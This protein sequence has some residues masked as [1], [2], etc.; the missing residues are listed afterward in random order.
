M[1]G[2]TMLF[3]RS[4]YQLYKIWLI[5][6]VVSFDTHLH[7]NNFIFYIL[8]TTLDNYM[9]LWSNIPTI[10]NIVK[11]KCCHKDV[12]EN[13]LIYTIFI[14][15]KNIYSSHICK[16]TSKVLMCYYDFYLCLSININYKNT[17]VI[18]ARWV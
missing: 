13:K 15:Y 1:M 10:Y 7:L 12:N 17:C 3:L 9:V 18:L 14:W 6:K 4:S 2:F 8:Y 11:N 16:Y 5:N